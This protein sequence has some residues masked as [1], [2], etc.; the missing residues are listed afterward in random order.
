VAILV[1][2]IS[3]RHSLGYLP[4]V[5]VTTFAMTKVRRFKVEE[6][7]I[8]IKEWRQGMKNIFYGFKASIKKCVGLT[9]HLFF[10]AFFISPA[11]AADFQIQPTT[12]DLGRNVKSGAFSVINNGKDK[13]DFQVSVKEWKQDDKGKDVYLDTKEIVYFPK[14]MSVEANSQRAVRIGLKTPPSAKEKTYRLFVE[15]IPTPKKVEDVDGNKKIKAG[16][17]IAFRFSIPIFVQPLKP[18]ESYALDRIEMTQ[19]TVKAIVKNTGNVHLK[20]RAVKFSGKAADG[21]EIFS[22]EVS[23]WYILNGLS[24]TYEA[25]IPKDVCGKLATIDMKAQT[26]NANINGTLNVQKNMCAQ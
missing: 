12:M 8:S 5:E 20:L 14:I 25:D 19:G 13:I 11:I 6:E 3:P 18:Q 22:K 26:E 7:K 10:V 15:E 17:M 1:S 16:V 21:K 24:L 23:G 4:S 9:A 2:R